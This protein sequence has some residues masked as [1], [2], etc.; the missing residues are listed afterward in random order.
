MQIRPPRRPALT[1]AVV[2]ALAVVLGLT[3][4][5]GTAEQAPPPPQP[6]SFTG[7]TATSADH[8][9]AL[10]D[11]FIPDP[12]PAGYPAG[13]LIPVDVQV[14]N[15][16][17]AVLSLIEAS[18]TGGGTAALID[19]HSTAT[20]P[21]TNYALPIG[22]GTSIPLTRQSG[23]FLQVRCAARALTAGTDVPMTFV[24]SNGASITADVPI[25]RF[26]SQN[27]S[28]GTSPDPNVAAC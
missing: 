25:G 23:Q 8:S 28:P 10:R 6:P 21:A 7:I 16:T 27:P 3:A 11:L 22:A 18:V 4:C 13:A 2:G 1:G 15:N 24:F 12:G 14:W 9:V 5:V 17:N 19:P 26:P 20:A